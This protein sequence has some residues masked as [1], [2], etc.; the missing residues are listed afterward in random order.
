M[1]L[2]VN[3]KV[4]YNCDMT[5]NLIGSPSLDVRSEDDQFLRIGELAART[6]LTQRTIRYYEEVGLLPPA[7]RTHG[8]YRLFSKRDVNRLDKILRLRDVFGFS[9][10]EIRNTIDAEETIEQLRTEYRATEDVAT[11]IM[12]L[13]QARILTEG[14]LELLERKVAQMKELKVE[15]EARLHRYVAKRNELVAAMNVQDPES[16]NEISGGGA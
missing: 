8:D 6:G 12:K 1:N 13:D 9:L 15:L 7:T 2:D 11:R 5:T 16:G 10:A 3:V 14:Q 4:R